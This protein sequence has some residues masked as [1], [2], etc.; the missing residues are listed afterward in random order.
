VQPVVT[1]GEFAVV[2]LCRDPPS[3]ADVAK[4]CRFADAAGEPGTVKTAT[5]PASV[6]P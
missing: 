1:P 5:F 4:L 2:L 3:S 6:R